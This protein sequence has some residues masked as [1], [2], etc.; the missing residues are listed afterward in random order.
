MEARLALPST[1]VNRS[2]QER[3][4]REWM[5]SVAPMEAEAAPLALAQ[6]A[7]DLL[8]EPNDRAVVRETVAE[9]IRQLQ[10]GL[11]QAELDAAL[12]TTLILCRKL[13]AQSSSSDALPL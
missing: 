7:L 1:A 3:T 13:Y 8:A 2:L 12:E 6:R 4:I 9:L 11:D 10:R 5:S